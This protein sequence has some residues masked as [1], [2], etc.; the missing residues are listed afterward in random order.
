MNRRAARREAER[1]AFR[2][3]WK[4]SGGVASLEAPAWI[5]L[6]LWLLSA[7]LGIID[8][9]GIRGLMQAELWPRQL[10]R[11]TPTFVGVGLLLG[12]RWLWRQVWKKPLKRE[13]G[14]GRE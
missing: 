3:G 5:L 12:L 1:Q 10:L 8:A 7:A 2:D 6:P 11:E 14:N 4:R 13:E 9:Y